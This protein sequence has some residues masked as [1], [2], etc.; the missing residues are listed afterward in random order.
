VYDGGVVVDRRLVIRG[1][2]FGQDARTRTT[3]GESIVQ[4]GGSIDVGFMVVADQ[5]TIDGTP[6]QTLM[7]SPGA[8][9]VTAG[10]ILP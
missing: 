8:A 4:N 2:K 10:C 1:A 7:T 5:V 6:G 3:T 9:A